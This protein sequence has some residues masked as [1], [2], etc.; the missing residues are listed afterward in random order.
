MYGEWGSAWWQW[1]F[2]VPTD[3]NPVADPTGEHCAA[4]QSGP[5]WF[6]AGTFGGPAERHCEVPTGKALFFPL[7]NSVHENN[8]CTDPDPDPQATFEELRAAAEADVAGAFDL[9]CVVDGVPLQNLENYAA[10]SPVPFDIILVENN[11]IFDLFGCADA[12]PGSYGPAA[13][14]GYWIMLAPLKPGPHTI[15]FGGTAFGGA[16]EV[17]ILYH[18]T[19][20]PGNR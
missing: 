11:V 7:F 10:S 17:D 15:H 16:F 5:V 1:A 14:A 8:L 12:L 20:V 13:S 4:G 2:G 6:L 9:F 18:L 3:E 19:F